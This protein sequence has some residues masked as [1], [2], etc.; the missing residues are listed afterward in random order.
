[1]VSGVCRMNEVNPRWT[2]LV[3]GWVTMFGWH[4][5]SV[6]NQATRS[7]QPCIPPG[8]LSRVPALAGDKGGNVTSVG[9][10]VTL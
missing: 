1:M 4:T 7:T 2:R 6:C 10:Q 3:L 8:S 9:W 5:I